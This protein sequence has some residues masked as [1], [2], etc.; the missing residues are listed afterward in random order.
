LISFGIRCTW[1]EEEV[2]ALAQKIAE[3]AEKA[4]AVPV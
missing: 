3:C 1:K 4:L 2:I